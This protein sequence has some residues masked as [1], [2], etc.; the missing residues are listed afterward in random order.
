MTG[1]V[2]CV[3]GCSGLRQ[4]WT[5]P[6]RLAAFATH[7]YGFGYLSYEEC[8]IDECDSEARTTMVVLFKCRGIRG[9]VEA[10]PGRE[11]ILSASFSLSSVAN[12]FFFFPLC[13]ARR[14]EA[15]R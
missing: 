8:L 1:G 9:P 4:G 2:L 3:H 5:G 10:S 6:P 15:R 13:K 14:G 11:P 7:G 12:L